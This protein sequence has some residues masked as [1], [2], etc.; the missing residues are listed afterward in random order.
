MSWQ[1]A[2]DPQPGDT[3]AYADGPPPGRLLI[4]DANNAITDKGLVSAASTR[5]THVP[6]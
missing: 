4:E 6:R 5:R 1:P 3:W 2:I